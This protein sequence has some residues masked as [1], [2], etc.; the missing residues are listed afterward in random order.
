MH[1][2]PIPFSSGCIILAQIF[3]TNPVAVA[4]K[5]L[6]QGDIG[7]FI[8]D[9]HQIHKAHHFDRSGMFRQSFGFFQ[10]RN[11]ATQSRVTAF[12]IEG[13]NVFVAKRFQ[14][15][16]HVKVNALAGR[17]FAGFSDV[18]D[19]GRH[20]LVRFSG[21]AANGSV[22]FATNGAFGTRNRR[23]FGFYD[24]QCIFIFTF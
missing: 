10:R 16:I 23:H 9:E 21:G 12:G 3:P 2:N 15:E 1:K 6:A 20:D 17:R 14:G 7:V 18:L 11:G 24:R 19:T 13:A 4:F 5:Q 8:E 22:A